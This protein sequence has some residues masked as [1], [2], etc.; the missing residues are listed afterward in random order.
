MAAEVAASSDLCKVT[1]RDSPDMILGERLEP[2]G[3]EE[4]H[5]GLWGG[6]RRHLT[7]TAGEI[8]RLLSGAGGSSQVLRPDASA[9]ASHK[10]DAVLAAVE[11]LGTSLDQTITSLE[12]KIDKVTNDLTLLHTD[13]HKLVDKT[14]SLECN[15]VDLAPQICQL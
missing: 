1:V 2:P 6:R 11:P 15:L 5:A 4:P 8:G 10:L 7:F 3:D 13:H 14:H 12:N 9:P